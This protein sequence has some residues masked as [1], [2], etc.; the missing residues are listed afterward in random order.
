MVALLGLAL[1]ACWV[2]LYVPRWQVS[3]LYS[4]VAR[5]DWVR[6]FELEN[7][8][9]RTLTQVVLGAFGLLVLWFTWRRVRANDRSVRIAEQGHI[10]DRFTQAVE[11]LGKMD[12]DRPNI[13]VR[14]GAIYAL[15]RIAI[16]SPRDHWTIMEILSAYVRRNAP[17]P[18]RTNKPTGDE[19]LV[20]PRTDIQAIV[21]VLGRRR[22]DRRRECAGI[23]LDLSECDLRAADLSSVNL[24]ETSFVGANLQGATLYK[25]ML[26]NVEFSG[27]DLHWVNFFEADLSN[28]DLTR[29]DLTGSSLRLANLTRATLSEAELVRVDL[30][31]A[32][33]MEVVGVSQE[34]VEQAWGDG[35]TRL[36]GY[37]ARPADWSAAR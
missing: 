5:R 25:A 27:A 31:G 28:A 12:G 23:Q 37:L 11:Q 3:V 14:L 10:T 24:T 13:E 7:E 21:T 34:Q 33:L 8:A 35:S 4:V 17:A 26:S 15:E 18:K 16:D 20:P 1:L 32:N 29:A 22:R 6:L 19:E 36:P 9:R 30:S 2:L